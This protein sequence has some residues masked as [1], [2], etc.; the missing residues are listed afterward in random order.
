MDILSDH[1]IPDC[2]VLI[3][4]LTAACPSTLRMVEAGEVPLKNKEERAIFSDT[5][6][7]CSEMGT[8]CTTLQKLD[9]EYVT[10]ERAL[11]S[12]PL[13]TRRNSFERELTQLKTMLSKEYTAREELAQWRE[14]T[15]NK[16]PSLYEDLKNGRGDRANSDE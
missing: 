13:V 3:T 4:T 12:H 8:I 6:R 16:I 14:K 11:S 10:A 5:T 9:E 15:L 1:A 7:F 2:T